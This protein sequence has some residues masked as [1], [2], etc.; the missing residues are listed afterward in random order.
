MVWTLGKASGWKN[1]KSQ[2][3]KGWLPFHGSVCNVGERSQAAHAYLTSTSEIQLVLPEPLQVFIN[4]CLQMKSRSG[5]LAGLH[6]N[7]S[8]LARKANLIFHPIFLVHNMNTECD[9]SC[10]FEQSAYLMTATLIL[11]RGS[12][13]EFVK[14][15]IQGVCECTRYC[16]CWGVLVHFK[17]FGCQ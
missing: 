2:E 10:V 13:S 7:L 6:G 1:G 16:R 14:A 4:L 11:L 3:Q 17:T 12:Y 5:S 8:V 15:L 9:N